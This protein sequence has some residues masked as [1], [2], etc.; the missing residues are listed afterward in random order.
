MEFLYNEV[1]Y[2]DK[3]LLIYIYNIITYKKNKV[4]LLTNTINYNNIYNI[5]IIIYI[6]GCKI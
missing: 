5:N 4:I 2:S 1:K 6:E 3:F